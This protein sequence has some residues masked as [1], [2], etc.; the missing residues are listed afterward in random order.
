MKKLRFI[1]KF[2]TKSILL[3]PGTFAHELMHLIVALLTGSK[4]TSFS[5]IP[6]LT[7]LEN[8]RYNA[9]FGSVG[10]IPRIQAF[11]ILVGMAP[12]LLWGVVALILYKINILQHY[13]EG[14]TIDLQR[15]FSFSS[16]WIWFMIIQLGWGGVPSVVDFKTS[17]KGFFSFSGLL[18]FMGIGAAIYL[19][20]FAPVIDALFPKP[21]MKKI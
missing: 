3:L 7:L 12:L 16:I 20:D 17:T 10:F 18:L 1:L 5:L 19:Y 14:A 4:I 2:W 13:G 21:Y 9:E 6:K 8:G 11:N 15:L